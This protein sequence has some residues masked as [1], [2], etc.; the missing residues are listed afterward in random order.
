[1]FGEA[2][3]AE[4]DHLFESLKIRVWRHVDH[5]HVIFAN[6]ILCDNI[7]WGLPMR[8]E[9][10]PWRQKHGHHD[11]VREGV[12]LQPCR[13]GELRFPIGEAGSSG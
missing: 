11:W 10:T 8:S 3:L 1:M 4:I 6:E 12:Q 7:R 5:G 2:K 13:F 9:D